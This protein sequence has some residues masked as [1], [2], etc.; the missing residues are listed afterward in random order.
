VNSP[1]FLR[2]NR[3]CTWEF[4]ALEVAAFGSCPWRNPKLREVI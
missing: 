2:G 1:I 3:R 4:I